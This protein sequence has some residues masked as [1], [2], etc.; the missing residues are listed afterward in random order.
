MRGFSLALKYER[1]VPRF[2]QPQQVLVWDSDEGAVGELARREEGADLDPAGRHRE[3]KKI[4]QAGTESI[5]RS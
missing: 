3:R 2:Q 5:L 1:E 4:S